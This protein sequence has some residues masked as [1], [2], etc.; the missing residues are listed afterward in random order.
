M[1]LLLQ[2][3]R[4]ISAPRSTQ[5][6]MPLSSQPGTTGDSPAHLCMASS[7]VFQSQPHGTPAELTVWLSDTCPFPWVCRESGQAAHARLDHRIQTQ[8]PAP[9][10][11]LKKQRLKDSAQCPLCLQL[12]QGEVFMELHPTEE[13]PQGRAVPSSLPCTPHRKNRD[14]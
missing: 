10:A 1:L 8:D 13:W 12:V 2:T 7:P 5:A 4:Q 9:K 6:V 3:H 14:V 11:R